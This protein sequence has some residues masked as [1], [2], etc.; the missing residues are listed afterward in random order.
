MTLRSMRNIV[1]MGL[2]PE[3]AMKRM[4]VA[5]LFVTFPYAVNAQ[6]VRLVD[7][8]DA[9]ALER[10]LATNPAQYEKVMGILEKVSTSVSCETLPQL[11]K[12]QYGAEGVECSGSLILTSEPPKRHLRFT[13]DDVQFAGN[14]VL[15]GQRG[16]LEKAVP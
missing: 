14:V 3:D 7:I 4:L 2:Q 8:G 6:T 5:L 9:R 11:L 10:I 15:A 12:V 16:K 13:L 1:V